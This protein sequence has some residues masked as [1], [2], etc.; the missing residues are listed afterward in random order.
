M[1]R[2]FLID[3]KQSK[4]TRLKMQQSNTCKICKTCDFIIIIFNHFC[5]NYRLKNKYYKWS[6]YPLAPTCFSPSSQLLRNHPTPNIPSLTSLFTETLFPYYFWRTLPPLV[7]TPFYPNSLFSTPC[8]IIYLSHNNLFDIVY[9]LHD[10][11]DFNNIRFH[12]ISYFSMQN[13]INIL[14]FYQK[15]AMLWEKIYV[16][17]T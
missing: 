4:K 2:T 16:S 17:N 11:I 7:S 8:R 13:S 6:A 14:N 12:K 10:R 1:L 3:L 9:I 5:L 15:P